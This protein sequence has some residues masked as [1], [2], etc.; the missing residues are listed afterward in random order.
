MVE[1][2]KVLRSSSVQVLLFSISEFKRII[3]NFL[4]LV[5]FINA[6]F[7]HDDDRLMDQHVGK[8]MEILFSKFEPNY[9]L[10]K[11]KSDLLG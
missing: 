1:I 5:I 11:D 10:G 4:L 8:N 6:P 2:L 7:Y 3:L 9:D